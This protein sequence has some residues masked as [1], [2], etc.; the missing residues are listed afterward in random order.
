MFLFFF[1]VLLTCTFHPANKNYYGVRIV[2]GYQVGAGTKDTGIYITLIGSKA[3]SGK[4]K[5][6]S[7]LKAFEGTFSRRTYD[8]L[9]VECDGDLGEILVVVVG[10]DAMWACLGTPWFVDFVTVHN[11]QSKQNDEFPC[12]YWIGSHECVSFTAH[13]SK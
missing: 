13:T 9:V 8:D 10:N 4:V 5:I 2:T 6:I 7:C 1:F 11:F 3:S 12:Y